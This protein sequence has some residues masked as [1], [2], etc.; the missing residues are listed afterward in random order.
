MDFSSKSIP[1]IVFCEN[2]IGR[3]YIVDDYF[4]GYFLNY[5]FTPKSLIDNLNRILSTH[6]ISNNTE[7]YDFDFSGKKVLLVEDNEI[8]TT[9]LLELLEERGMYVVCS[10]DGKDATGK[11]KLFSFD[12]ILMDIQM[13][14]MDGYEATKIIIKELGSKAPPIIAMTA[15]IL[16][17][18]KEYIKSIGMRGFISKPINPVNLFN[19][20]KRQLDALDDEVFFENTTNSEKQSPTPLDYGQY[21]SV[22]SALRQAG[23]DTNLAMPNV[24]ND[25]NRFYSL[26]LRYVGELKEG[27][28]QLEKNIF[29]GNTSHKKDLCHN[30]KGVSFNLGVQEIGALLS[31]MENERDRAVLSSQLQK[32]NVVIKKFERKLADIRRHEV[33]LL[34]DGKSEKKRPLQSILMNLVPLLQI[35]DLTCLDCIA[36]LKHYSDDDRVIVLIEQIE[37]MEF[38]SAKETVY[39]ISDGKN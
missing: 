37:N 13:P 35:G 34:T 15:N 31:E 33:L 5:V 14:I 38:E 4:N 26:L 9:I 20:V 8:N 27:Y 6:K 23:I 10:S 25:V 24:N 1:Y 11:I 3:E 28:T 17:N 19:V 30:L 16:G 12:I 22:L 39:F 2:I 21:S 18:D 36:E 7:L 32:L 29:L